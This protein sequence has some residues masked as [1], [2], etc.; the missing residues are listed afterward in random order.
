MVLDRSVSAGRRAWFAL[1]G[2][3]LVGL[4]GATSLTAQ[5]AVSPVIVQLPHS[6]EGV[7][8][9]IR[10][11]NEGE[12]L[13]RF[14]VYVVDYDQDRDGN[15]RFV[16]AGTDPRSCA[17]RLTFSPDVLTVPAGGRGL[18]QIRLAPGT[19]PTCWSMLFV[20]S[21]ATRESVLRINQRIG[22][23]VYG[24]G[25]DQG[26]GGELVAADARSTG[27]SVEVGFAFR[28]MGNWPLRPSGLVEIRS[29]TGQLVAATPV[30]AFS[31]L[32]GR[33][34]FLRLSV[35]VDSIE[36]GRYLAV[37]ILDFGGEYLAGARADFRVD[38]D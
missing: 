6:P 25:P 36:P 2:L 38:G 8:A 9:T 16:P 23:K 24:L 22:V 29:V 11:D 5:F 21:P 34:R 31:V 27:N 4:T 12:D 7:D 37:P 32:P 35:P 15:H 1:A 10:I 33:E 18:V 14:R 20:E 30:A 3:W 17:E 28:N 26:E 19:A 13:M